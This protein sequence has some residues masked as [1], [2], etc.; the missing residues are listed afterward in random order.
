MADTLYEVT[1]IQ[2]PSVGRHVQPGGMHVLNFGAGCDV[3]NAIWHQ[4]FAKALG[5]EGHRR[6]APL[7]GIYEEI[8]KVDRP[9][10]PHS[11]QDV[12]PGCSFSI[13][14]SGDHKIDSL[15]YKVKAAL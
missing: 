4:V 11:R 1:N 15:G 5:R 6:H 9:A 2:V 3:E 8:D 7:R 10:R 14:P 12:R 13:Y